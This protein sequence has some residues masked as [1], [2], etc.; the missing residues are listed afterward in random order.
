MSA[1]SSVMNNAGRLAVT[2]GAALQGTTGL[3]ATLKSGRTAYVQDNTPV[4]ERTYHAKFSF[5]PNGI[6]LPVNSVHDVFRGVNGR[7]A[8]VLSVQV[9][10]S[11][12][13]YAVRVGAIEASGA[14][15]YSAWLTITDAPHSIEIAWGAAST[16][17]ATN[18]TVDVWI[19]NVNHAGFTN[20]GNGAFRV[21]AARLGPQVVP[22]QATGTEFLDAFVSNRSYRIS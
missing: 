6:V 3:A 2:N 17:S 5:D 18:G 4:G 8:A 10:A 12:A 22:T 13:G 16:S 15:R 11:G 21:E 1:W 9:K 19:D 14:L 7:D 20:L